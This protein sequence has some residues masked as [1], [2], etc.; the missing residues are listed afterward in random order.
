ML[1]PSNCQYLPITGDA[2]FRRYFRVKRDIGDS[3][4]LMDAPPD[5]ETPAAF[6]E[7]TRR[8]LR[9][10]ARAPRIYHADVDRGFLLLEDFGDD[11]YLYRATQGNADQ[12]YRS[13]IDMLIKVQS[14]DH[15][16]LPA[17]GADTMREEMNLFIDWL[18]VKHLDMKPRRGNMQIYD[19]AFDR[20][21]ET[22]LEQPQ[23]FVHRD[24]HSR[25]LFALANGDTPG[26][27][28]YQDAV[29]GPVSYDL[30]SLLKDCYLAWP[31]E[32]TRHWILYFLQRYRDAFGDEL[33]KKVFTRWLDLMG[34]QRH[35]K[36][37]GI[38]ARLYHRD[39]KSG[40]LKDIPRTLR[41]IRS[42]CAHYPEFAELS[43]RMDEVLR[44][45]LAKQR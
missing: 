1:A 25:N 21:I 28:D 22:A 3:V 42:C 7:V 8:L 40:Y 24:Y 16:G 20:L 6:V 9:A 29:V 41:Y 44:A 39:K 33:D 13:A 45:T 18:L 30:V 27:V 43:V 12:L 19:A 26:L 37:S 5:R 17:F 4:I 14:A 36:A 15:H 2:S 23:T 38:F 35:F 10:H 31:L 34:I 32:K 11:L